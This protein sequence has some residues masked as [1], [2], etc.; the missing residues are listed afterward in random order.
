MAKRTLL[1]FVVI[2]ALA[3]RVAFAFNGQ[4]VIEGPL[5]LVIG[6]VGDVTEYDTPYEVPVT[7][8]NSGPESLEVQLRIGGLADPWEA[9][10]AA[11][12]NVSIPAGGERS[13][14]FTICVRSEAYSA[15]YPVHVDA[16]FT[17]AD[18]QR[19]AHAVRV[20]ETRFT[21][22]RDA[23]SS[24]TELPVTHLPPRGAVLLTD[25]KA[26]RV[27]WAYFEQAE[28][29]MPVGWQGEAQP[30][31][32]NFAIGPVARGA[33]R[34]A[35]NMH[36]AWWQGRGTVF[37]DY[38]IKLPN[39]TPIVLSFA[40]AIR[41]VTPPEP[42]SDGVTFRVLVDG[43]VVFDRHTDSRVWV[44]GQVDLSSLAGEQIQLRL[45]CHPGPK[46]DTTCDS[47]YWGNP[48]LTSGEQPT[49]LT[50]QDREQLRERA[51][52]VVETGRSEAKGEFAFA[53]ADD[54][55]AAVVMGP[56]G[57]ADGAIGLGKE[58]TSVVFDGLNVSVMKHRLGAG[59]SPIAVVAVDTQMTSEEHLRIVHRCTLGEEAFDLIAKVFAQAGGLR[60]RLEC[61]QRITDLSVGRFDRTAHRVYYGHGYCVV[62]P[63]VFRANYG[64]HDLSTSHVG[65]DFSN[66]VSLLTAC[67]NPPD[68]MEV[69]SSE[70]I[71]ALHTHMDGT[72]TLVP[73]LRGVVDCA[74]K[75]RALYDREPS[76]GYARKAGRFV[77]DIWGGRYAD[78]AQL[79]QQMIDYGLTDSLL[80]LH[81]WQRWGYDYRLPDI[82]PP[83]PDLGTVDDL[84]ELGAVCD[85]AGIPWGLHDN[86]IDMYPDA[87]QFS[88]DHICFTESGEPIKAWLNTGRDAQSYRFRPDHIMPFV[89]RNLE[90]IGPSLKPS[91]Y[92]IDVFTSINMF[93]FY[94]RHGNFHSAL[95][96]RRHWGE[97]FRWIQDYLGP[98]T[99]TTSEAGDDQLVGDLDGA[100]CQ[101]LNLSADGGYFQH[102]VPC[103]DWERFPWFDVVL[104]DRFSLHGVGYPGRYEGGRSRRLH[105][106]ESDDYLSDEVL[107]GHALMI[108]RS[109]LPRGAA[110][111]Y[112]LA[113]DFIR[114]IATDTIDEIEFAD[115][116]IHRI[117]VTW[118]SGAK[119]HVNRGSEDW[120]IAGRVLPQYGYYATNGKIESAIERV[121]GVIV[122]RS[123]SDRQLYVNA[124]GFNPD[125]ALDITPRATEV[126]HLGGRRFALPIAWKAQQPAPKDLRVS[127]RF[128]S[129][130]SRR[131]DKVAFQDDYLAS[132]GS[133]TWQGEVVTGGRQVIEIPEE[134]G[135]GRYEIH[136]ALVDPATRARYALDAEETGH[137]EYVLGE[138]IVDG[139]GS[140]VTDVRV[141][142]HDTKA[143]PEPRWNVGGKAL[144]LGPATTSGAFRCQWTPTTIVMTPLPNEPSFDVSLDAGNLIDRTDVNVVGVRAIDRAGAPLRDVSATVSGATVKFTTVAGEFAYEI[145]LEP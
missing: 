134:F 25:T 81:V 44:D 76:P 111:K 43:K 77:F 61:P 114:S 1:L 116:D 63:Q 38:R 37:V 117:T 40:N 69:N 90:L 52:T 31:R 13:T 14:S 48:V 121:D 144:S 67:D 5:R 56:S 4:D 19:V 58:G 49:P 6:P 41:D 21:Q 89:Q 128:K 108:D 101:H 120:A 93:D 29:S 47:A 129:P 136:V 35:L 59:P 135:A 84:R 62:E 30:S 107:L 137:H 68:F 142:P 87:D 7:V 23:A 26:F 71:Y 11:E 12:K 118:R 64:G 131:Y 143:R 100:D 73:S 125:P 20:F 55:C 10:G 42:S 104:H 103:Q 96:T 3:A 139:A 119:V 102:R 91:H 70:Q 123:R 138:L 145:L 22:P 83:N 95:E 51:R 46:H 122:E 39:T 112:W 27:G 98:G 133:G 72:L 97:A 33:T 105:G 16:T 85:A 82:Y 66:G 78:N 8:T 57:L 34:Q 24:P 74:K 2:A 9:V 53:L 86:Y 132:P 130:R 106:I 15:L 28:V 109:S 32:A 115:G 140:M 80:T 126:Q 50:E 127:L 99:I 94:D 124:R 75:Y 18:Q 79:M 65:F 113:Q 110:V 45:L 141:E 36:P 54:L 60:I 88:Y 17:Q 92:F